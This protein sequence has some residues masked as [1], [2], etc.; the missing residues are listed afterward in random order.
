MG[1][2][3]GDHIQEPVMGSPKHVIEIFRPNFDLI[4]EEIGSPIGIVFRVFDN[5]LDF[6]IGLILI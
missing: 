4:I 3:M 6:C 1:K 5:K 2:F